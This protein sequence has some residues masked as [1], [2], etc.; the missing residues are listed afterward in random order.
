MIPLCVRVCM[1]MLSHKRYKMQC[2]H[3]CVD[4]YVYMDVHAYKLLH[5][6]LIL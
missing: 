2:L 4:V 1:H 3:M 6:E 5:T